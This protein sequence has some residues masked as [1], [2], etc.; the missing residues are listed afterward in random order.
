VSNYSLANYAMERF[1]EVD[2]S[3]SEKNELGS[4]QSA[5]DQSKKQ[6]QGVQ[7]HLNNSRVEEANSY[8]GHLRTNKR[9]GT[10]Y[11]KPLNERFKEYKM[12]V[13]PTSRRKRKSI[14]DLTLDVGIDNLL[15][16]LNFNTE[17]KIDQEINNFVEKNVDRL[18]LDYGSGDIRNY[19]G[20][21]QDISGMR[22]N[23]Q[24]LRQL[25]TKKFMDTSN[26]DWTPK[27]V[28]G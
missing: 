17:A 25:H 5:F 28:K 22:K 19:P 14:T 27:T 9:L 3:S 11:I 20:H 21:T 15:D 6:L 24:S 10:S 7:P 23:I 16:K 12:V 2:M 1:E 4:I 26:L 8:N 13:N 18:C